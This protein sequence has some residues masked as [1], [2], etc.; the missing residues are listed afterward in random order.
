VTSEWFKK[1]CIG[2]VTTWESLVENFV[3]K[4]YQLF[5]D[6]KEMEFDEDVDPD[7]IAKI[8]KIDDNLF[9]YEIPLCKAFN[10]FNYLLKINMDL[11]TFDIQG[12]GTYVEYELKNT[13]T[14]DL[15][16]PW[17][18]NG[19]PYQLCDHICEP[20]RFKNGMTKWP[21]CSS[22]I[23]GFCNDGELPGM[24]RV[25]C[26][27]YFQDHKWYDELVDVKLKEETLMHKAKVEESWGDVTPSVM[28]LC[29][30]LK[31]SFE[32]FHEL[33]YNVLVK[34][35]ECWRKVSAHEVAPFTRWENYGQGPYA[36][37]KTKRAYNPYL[38]INCI[39]GRNYGAD[40]A[41]YTQD[42]QE[43]KKEHHDPSTCRVRRF[44][45]IKYSFD[46]EDE[47]VAIK[48]H[49]CSNHL[50]TN[51][52][53]CQAYQELFLIM[54]EGWLVMNEEKK[55]EKLDTTYVDSRIRRIDEDGNPARANIKQ[56]LGYRKDGDGD[57]KSQFLRCVKAS[58]N[59]DVK[60]SFTS[61]QDGEPLQDDVRLCL[62]NDLKK[63]QDHNPDLK[64]TY[65]DPPP[66][67]SNEFIRH[68]KSGS[69]SKPYRRGNKKSVVK[70]NNKSRVGKEEQ[71]ENRNEEVKRA[72]V[73]D[74][75]VST[76]FND[77]NSGNPGKI[78]VNN[79]IDSVSNS[80]A[81]EWKNTNVQGMKSSENFDARHSLAN[82]GYNKLKYVPAI[83][84][85]IGNKVVDMDPVVEEGSK[86]WGLAFIGYFVKIFNIPLEAWNVE[87]ISRISCRLD[88]PLI[89][90]KITT[91][92]CERKYGRANYAR[93]LIEV[94]AD[95]ALIESIEIYYK[96]LGKSMMLDTGG[97]ILGW[98]QKKNAKIKGTMSDGL[99]KNVET[100]N[101][102]AALNEVIEEDNETEWQR[103]K[104]IIDLACE[105]HVPILNKEMLS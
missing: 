77:G 95:N 44:E 32:N 90:D 56:A 89:M 52:D 21:M 96:S 45:M 4:F 71:D 47:Y 28:K 50:K 11:F 92:I 2:S 65:P 62:G 74:V 80:G 5:D 16:E 6:N 14:R 55:K 53:T 23:D 22:D 29:A 72:K 69:I 91:M 40:N 78:S 39:F 85:E 42:N 8:F 101:R 76:V 49:E 84:N 17:L 33:D 27:T 73:I 75:E 19:E 48:E 66:K 31:S 70:L 86:K 13:M 87:G 12:I 35:E 34:L 105:M 58:A 93:V 99:K 97:R 59:S 64:P 51:I 88:N 41:S 67:F 38:D 15:K 18:D 104:H 102:F 79:N 103:L 68:N 54:D 94:D 46:A 83:V 26:L 82:S 10:D 7:D 60:Y 81:N 9:D 63:A 20:Y 1:D 61:A 24:V 100:T 25:R 3:Q 36:N 30:W 57:G 37:A 98:N 43:H